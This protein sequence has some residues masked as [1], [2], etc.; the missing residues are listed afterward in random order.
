MNEI[1]TEVV[2]HD[3]VKTNKI[4]NGKGAISLMFMNAGNANATLFSSTP[5]NVGDSPITIECDL[6]INERDYSEIPITFGAGTTPLII[7]L[8]KQIASRYIGT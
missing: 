2:E 1:K 3:V 7:V 5:L 4:V 6:D 8:K